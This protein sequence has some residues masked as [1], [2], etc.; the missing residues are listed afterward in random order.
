MSQ[1]SLSSGK[2]KRKF[3]TLSSIQKRVVLTVS[4]PSGSH[5]GGLLL[6]GDLFVWDKANDN[7]TTFVTPLSRMENRKM[8]TLL[9]K[10]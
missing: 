9:L 8:D 1:L 7:L 3:P 5:I 10:G 6:E 4:T 2:T